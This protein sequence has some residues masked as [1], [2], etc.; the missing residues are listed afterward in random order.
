MLHDSRAAYI[1]AESVL[2]VRPALQYIGIAGH[3]STSTILS[4]Y[5]NI[6]FIIAS[7]SRVHLFIYVPVQNTDSFFLIH[8]IILLIA[9]IIFVTIFCYKMLLIYKSQNIARSFF[10]KRE[11]LTQTMFFSDLHTILSKN[12]EIIFSVILQRRGTFT[13]P[14]TF[15]RNS[16]S[17]LCTAFVCSPLLLLCSCMPG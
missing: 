16:Y 15:S 17:A 2:L 1:L 6:T 4:T 7:N 13:I 14:K 11:H 9:E 12:Y 8:F 3:N 5:L 10:Y